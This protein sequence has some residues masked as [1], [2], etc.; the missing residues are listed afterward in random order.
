MRQLIGFLCL[1]ITA[2]L[3]LLILA[4]LFFI[5]LSPEDYLLI[6]CWGIGLFLLSISIGSFFLNYYPTIWT[7]EEGLY[8]SF[9][10]LF[11]IKVRWHQVIDVNE[12]QGFFDRAMLVRVKKVMPL[13]I[14]YSLFYSGSLIPGFLFMKSIQNA[15]ELICEIRMRARSNASR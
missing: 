9:F 3:Y 6:P 13:H 2:P 5:P 14:L 1:L 15:D 8:L 7:D 11:R 10:L 12:R 4:S